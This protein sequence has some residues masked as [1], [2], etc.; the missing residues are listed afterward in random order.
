MQVDGSRTDFNRY[1]VVPSASRLNRP[2]ADGRIGFIGGTASG[3]TRR[4]FVGYLN[5]VGYQIGPLT[6]G[7]ADPRATR[8]AVTNGRGARPHRTAGGSADR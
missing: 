5:T 6:R 3:R 1:E 2:S 7:A 8:S 4:S